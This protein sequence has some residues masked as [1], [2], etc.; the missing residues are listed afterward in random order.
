MFATRH[1]T[2][3]GA[4][5]ALL[6]LLIGTAHCET[7]GSEEA[8]VNMDRGS[9]G[10]MLAGDAGHLEDDP[11]GRGR[12][13]VFAEAPRVLRVLRGGPSEDRLEVDDVIL[14]V[15]GHDVASEKGSRLLMRPD[16][17]ENLVLTVRRGDDEMDITVI[18]GQYD[19]RRAE[20]YTFDVVRR[21][22]DGRLR[23]VTRESLRADTGARSRSFFVARSRAGSRGSTRSWYG[24]G[25]ETRAVVVQE[26]GDEWSVIYFEDPPKVY[27][28]DPGGPAGRAGIRR[29]DFLV[30]IDG[31]DLDKDAG[32]VIFSSTAPGDTVSLLVRRDGKEHVI[33]I[34]PEDYPLRVVRRGPVDHRTIAGGVVSGR[35][36]LRYAG[37][38][39]NVDVEVRGGGEVTVSK[40]P[41][42]IIID[43]GSATVRLNLQQEDDTGGDE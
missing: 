17:G 23:A 2:A 37:T 20:N 22:D 27:K 29:G 24:V 32:A 18:V 4:L 1:L 14:Q 39:G 6:V 12:Y 21:G 10:I 26:D 28:V 41:G 38:V 42:E 33:L 8:V 19:R 3:A 43:T 25:L 13:W 7:R 31:E 40:T 11:G 9:L 30:Q 5:V 16:R 36:H 35:Q 34:T 15:D